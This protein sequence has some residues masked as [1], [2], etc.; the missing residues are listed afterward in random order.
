MDNLAKCLRYY[1]ADRLNNDPGWRN[2]TVR[3]FGCSDTLLLS[4]QMR[5]L[6]KNALFSSGLSYCQFKFELVGC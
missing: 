1:I 5:L 6:G 4:V 2:V 3:A